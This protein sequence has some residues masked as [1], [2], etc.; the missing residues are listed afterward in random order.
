[1]TVR[2]TRPYAALLGVVAVL[3]VGACNGDG[4]DPATPSTGASSSSATSGTTTSS[5]STTATTTA[6]AT[7]D[8]ADLPPEAQK[9]TPEGAAAFVK[10]YF[11]QANESWTRPDASLLPP[12]SEGGCQSCANLIKTAQELVAQHQ[13][14][15]M[16]PVTVTRATAFEGGAGDQ[17]LVRASLRQRK[18]DVL[19]ASGKVVSSDPAAKVSRTA[20]LIWRNGQWLMYG[21]AE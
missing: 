21:L 18:V 6:T 3:A 4:D 15:S 19:D 2:R 8:P 20:S 7:I 16:G 12:L 17:Q 11:Q 13:R 9:H 14:Y 5:P 10:Y 1:M